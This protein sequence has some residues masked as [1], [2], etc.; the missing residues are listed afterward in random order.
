MLSAVNKCRLHFLHLAIFGWFITL[1]IASNIFAPDPACWL[2]ELATSL[3]SPSIAEL[4]CAPD[5]TVTPFPELFCAF[6][7]ETLAFS[8]S[9]AWIIWCKFPLSKF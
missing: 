5:D 8:G 6:D 4:F 1:L 7:A 3:L 9:S 2:P